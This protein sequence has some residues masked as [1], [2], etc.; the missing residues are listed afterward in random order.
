M[1]IRRKQAAERSSER[2]DHHGTCQRGEQQQ[3]QQYL[4]KP[5]C[6]HRTCHGH[7]HGEH[8]RKRRQRLSDENQFAAA[9]AD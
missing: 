6:I 1:D 7:G 2:G 4:W 3:H 5:Q 8:D 9:K